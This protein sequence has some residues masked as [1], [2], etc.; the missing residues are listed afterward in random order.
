LYTRLKEWGITTL[1]KPAEEYGLGLTIGNAEIR[2]LE[3]TNVYA[4]L[5]RLG[6]WRPVRLIVPD[7]AG[8]T[9]APRTRATREHCW[10]IADIL[11]DNAAREPAFGAASSLRFDFPVACKTGTSTDFRDNWAMAYTPEF[12]VGVWVGNFNGAPM[13]EVSGVTGAA[14]IMNDVMRYLWR[15]FGTTWYERPAGIEEHWVDALS[16]KRVSGGGQGRVREKFWARNLPAN[17]EPS[18]YDPEGR[19]RLPAEYGT[20]AASLDNH[21]GNRV[22]IAQGGGLHLVSPTPGATFVIDPDI[23]TSAWVPLQAAGSERMVW[24]SESLRLEERAGKSFAVA[25]EGEHRLT[26][27]DPESGRAVTTWIRV[28][29]L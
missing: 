16:G 25:Q 9:L 13:R 17:A 1:P 14:P 27:R 15:R 26:V 4:T 28:K 21:L 29:R 11:S 24:E 10:L 7:E 23:P 6:E 19:V 8:E 2:L 12:T 5:A 3:L 20:W 18:D 22:V